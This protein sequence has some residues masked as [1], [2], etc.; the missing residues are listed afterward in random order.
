MLSMPKT[1]RNLLMALGFLSRLT[2]ATLYSTQIEAKNASCAEQETPS[3]ENPQH[4]A[5]DEHNPLADSVPWFPL[6]GALLGLLA[7]LLPWCG[8]LVLPTFSPV[9]SAWLYVMMLAYLTRA[10]HW[11][12]LADI[13]DA[14]GSNATGEK[15]WTI[16]KDSRVGAFGVLGLIFGLSAQ[17]IALTLCVEK[18]LWN[19]L[20]IAPAFGRAM[21]IPLGRMTSPARQSWLARA[22]LPGTQR[23]SSLFAYMATLAACICCTGFSVTAL[24]FI[25]AALALLA[26]RSTAAQ[27]GGCNGDFCGTAII[28]GE[29]ALLFAAAIVG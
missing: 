1:P 16:M 13:S 18:G 24:A 20:V 2:P 10:L 3:F 15:F 17:L 6:A 9:V 7:T 5:P 28:A 29:T 22:I 8:A 27:H 21:I 14:C 25:P 26:L 23:G 12:A 19:V 11:D 4:N